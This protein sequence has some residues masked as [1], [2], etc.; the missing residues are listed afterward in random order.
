M[1]C[2]VHHLQGLVRVSSIT[3]VA[4]SIYERVIL[5]FACLE[6]R[7]DI[8]HHQS[9]EMALRVGYPASGIINYKVGETCSWQAL[10]RNKHLPEDSRTRR[11]ADPMRARYHTIMLSFDLIHKQSAVCHMVFRIRSKGVAITSSSILIT[12]T[13]VFSGV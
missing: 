1:H 7:G 2:R 12:S 4:D 11:V 10:P 5:D 6:Y 3:L 13:N 9:L 8:Y